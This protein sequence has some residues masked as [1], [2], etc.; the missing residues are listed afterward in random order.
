MNAEYLRAGNASVEV[1]GDYC[2]SRAKQLE[3]HFAM[4]ISLRARN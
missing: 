3:L 2:M 1:G 4:H